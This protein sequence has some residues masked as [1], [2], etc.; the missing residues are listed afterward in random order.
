M[1]TRRPVYL[2]QLNEERVAEPIRERLLDNGIHSAVVVPLLYLDDAVGVLGLAAPDAKHLEQVPDEP[3]TRLREIMRLVIRRRLTQWD[4]AMHAW[5][6]H[7]PDVARIV[8][9]VDRTRL[10]V[11]TGLFAGLGFEGEELQT[12]AR[13]FVT[14]VSLER[15]ILVREGRRPRLARIGRLL[16]IFT[17]PAG[18]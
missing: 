9:D 18:A 15:G 3:R 13:L 6:T 16:E 12:R 10:R 8:R 17:A 4:L 11:V 7:E 5:A 14:Y 2:P 1:R